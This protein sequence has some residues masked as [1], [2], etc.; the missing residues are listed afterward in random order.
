MIA[1]VKKSISKAKAKSAG[2]KRKTAPKKG[3]IA[4]AAARNAAL[5]KE[6]A[7][8]AMRA[9][10]ARREA[11]S[12]AAALPAQKP[13]AASSK[14]KSGAARSGN[15]PA[16]RISRRARLNAQ[17]AQ[18]SYM[19]PPAAA[20]EYGIGDAVEVVCDYDRDGERVRGWAKGVVVQVENK[21]V[22]VQ[23]RTN[24]F[25]TDGWMV[26][27]RILW[28]G[29]GSDQ[30]RHPGQGRRTPAIAVPIDY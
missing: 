21:L 25:L 9:R 13:A 28:Y 17:L 7:A 27:D 15:T 1:K 5:A 24:V 18:F 10:A 8:G 26:P 22:A 16:Q 30:I 3:S 12:A 29:V 11:E 2:S 20:G 23:F 14:R 6:Q 19:K 4:A